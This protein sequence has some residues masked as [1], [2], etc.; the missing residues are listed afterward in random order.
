MTTLMQCRKCHKLVSSGIHAIRVTFADT[1]LCAGCGGLYGMVFGS[2]GA[3]A[4]NELTVSGML[5]ITGTWAMYG[6]VMAV[7]MGLVREILRVRRSF[8][9][10]AIRERRFSVKPIPRISEIYGIPAT[11]TSMPGRA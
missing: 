11:K 8:R 3:Q 5:T 10:E 9:I 1:I 6:V 4:R 2:F 7:A